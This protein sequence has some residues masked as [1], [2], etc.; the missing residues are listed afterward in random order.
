[1][2]GQFIRSSIVLKLWLTIVAMVVFVFLALS[3]LLQQS[4]DGYIR[5]QETPQL[6]KTATMAKYLAG[7]NDLPALTQLAAIE[8]VHIVAG[9]YRTHPQLRDVYEKLPEGLRT[10]L[11]RQHIVTQR[12]K[13]GSVDALR[14]NVPIHTSDGPGLV[15]ISQ[16]TKVLNQPMGHLRNITSLAMLLGIVMVTGLAFVISNN[17]SRPLIQMNRVAEEMARGDF[18]GKINVV[19][20]DEVGKLGNTFNELAHKLEQSIEALHVE[21]DQLSSILTSLQDGVIALDLNGNINLANPPGQRT[22]SSMWLAKSGDPDTPRLPVELEA[23]LAKVIE[24]NHLTVEEIS[25]QDRQMQITM[26]PLYGQDQ[27][28]R[29]TVGVLRDVTEERRLD[30]LRKDFIA[31][32]SHELRTPLSMMQGYSEA[33]LDDFGDDAD[34]RRS[35]H[36]II[37]DESLRMRRLV[38]DL[39][40]FAQLESG[41]FQMNIANCDVN[42]LVRRTV[43][44]FHALAK[45]QGIELH[46][47]IPQ[48]HTLIQADEDRLE[49]VFTNLLD[50]AIRHTPNG[51]CVSVA[52]NTGEHY[53]NVRVSDTG[54]GIPNEDLPYIWE[55]FYKADKARTRGRAGLGLGLAITKHIVREHHGDIVVESTPQKGTTFTVSLPKVQIA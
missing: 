25:W 45:D 49:Q 2:I 30:R 37:H 38:N 8:R 35:L 40:D 43:R 55:R 50:N 47:D 33:L 41:Q 17:L 21:R 54:L 4:L 24:T 39:L 16:D 32:V 12:V 5:N 31:N 15:I 52:V 3:I 11:K 28:L 26:A 19:T 42:Q 23:M 34:Q 51:G 13:V 14:V 22:L 9:S 18:G 27:R 20:R 6:M 1:M 44:K 48:A 53:T 29:G 10:L 36:E 46:E 7:K